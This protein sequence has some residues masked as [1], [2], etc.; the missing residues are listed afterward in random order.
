MS[1]TSERIFRLRKKKNF[2]RA[3]LSRLVSVSKTTIQKWEEG[4]T[5][6]RRDKLKLMSEIFEVDIG[7]LLGTQSLPTQSND[8]FDMIL[9]DA[10]ED[11]EFQITINP[12]PGT[13]D[14]KNKPF[15]KVYEVYRDNPE[16]RHLFLEIADLINKTK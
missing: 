8:D 3:E 2:S 12:Y 14:Y 13:G 16:Y 5:Y 7:Y 1:I 11:E 4:T 15:I 9:L 10:L 6:P